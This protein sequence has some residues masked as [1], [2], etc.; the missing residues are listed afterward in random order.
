MHRVEEVV[1]RDFEQLVEIGPGGKIPV[2][3]CDDG[4]S[5]CESLIITRY[6]N[7][8]ADGRLLPDEPPALLHCLETES[9]ASVLMDSL[10][11]RSTENNRREE[12]Q[13][14][15][16]LLER[17]TARCGRCYDRLDQLVGALGDQVTLAS[18]AVVSALGYA[19]WRAAEDHWAGGR[20]SLK[21]YYDRLLARP[22]FAETEPVF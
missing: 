3:I 7:D 10:F 22:A 2:L 1:I 9:V 16:S 15:A 18:I 13:R 8:L 6:L 14:S 19:N 17:E 20:D 11:V 21:G 5:L 12:S 4:T